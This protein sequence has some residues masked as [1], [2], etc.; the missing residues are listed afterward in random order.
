MEE[1]QNS[2]QARVVVL[3]EVKTE[4]GDWTLCFQRCRYEF[5]NRTNEEGF[6]FILRRPDGSLQPARG[7]ARI[8]S[9]EIGRL[10]ID[11]AIK[12]G[13]GKAKSMERE[14]PALDCAN[15]LEGILRSYLNCHYNDFGVKAN[16]NLLNDWRSPVK[17]AL[18][19]F[20][21]ESNRSQAAK[22]KI[23]NFVDYFEG[24]GIDD[25]AARY[26]YYDFESQAAVY[27]Y[28]DKKI[29]ELAVLLNV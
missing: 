17:F 3:D 8:P 16:N 15:K 2:T 4:Q 26:E 22:D 1:K 19:V 27:E 21:G 23:D 11:K 28:V 12:K 14:N 18:G 9:T 20:Y 6:R 10:L 29:E 13:W 7:Q 24:Q 25:L 5:G